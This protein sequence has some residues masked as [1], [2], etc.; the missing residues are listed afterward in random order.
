MTY[1][2]NEDVMMKSIQEYKQELQPIT[3]KQVYS[4][5]IPVLPQEP[6]PTRKQVYATTPKPKVSRWTPPTSNAV[7]AA[8]SQ[9]FKISPDAIFCRSHQWHLVRPRQAI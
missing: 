8:A 5:C 7:I 4:I 3:R 9:V 2:Y 6:R 1:D